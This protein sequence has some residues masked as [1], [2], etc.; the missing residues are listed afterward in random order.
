MNLGLPGQTHS[1][2]Y[3]LV[4]FYHIFINWPYI[5]KIEVDAG[6]KTS[7]HETLVTNKQFDDLIF[8]ERF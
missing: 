2:Y 4:G 8:Y 1:S 3:C 5:I 7:A 6:K